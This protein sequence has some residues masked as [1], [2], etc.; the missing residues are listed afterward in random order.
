[1]EKCDRCG[2]EIEGDGY[3]CGDLLYCDLCYDDMVGDEDE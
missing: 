3:R 2:A 1:M